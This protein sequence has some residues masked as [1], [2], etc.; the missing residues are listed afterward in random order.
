MGKDDDGDIDYITGQLDGILLAAVMESSEDKAF[1]EKKW[2]DLFGADVTYNT[3]PGYPSDEAAR[4]QEDPLTIMDWDDEREVA[5]LVEGA[6]V[7]TD[8]TGWIV[9]E[10]GTVVTNQIGEK[11]MCSLSG[12]VYQLVARLRDLR[13]EIIRDVYDSD[14]LR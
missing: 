4:K 12:P 11:L 6:E 9:F 14:S 2:R 13:L 8:R 3:V 7:P 10:D 1:D 5:T